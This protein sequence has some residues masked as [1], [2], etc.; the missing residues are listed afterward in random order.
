MSDSS[1]DGSKAAVLSVLNKDWGG[2][3]MVDYGMTYYTR[4]GINSKKKG[5]GEWR[6]GEKTALESL[7]EEEECHGPVWRVLK[8]STNTNTCANAATEN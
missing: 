5:G 8:H 2:S 7:Q 4:L 3:N 6:I 1:K